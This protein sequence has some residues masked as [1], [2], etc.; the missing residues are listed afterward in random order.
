MERLKD[1]TNFNEEMFKVL[2]IMEQKGFLLESDHP[3]AYSMQYRTAVNDVCEWLSEN[4]Y[5]GTL[6]TDG[7]YD[8]YAGAVY[9]LYD[10]DRISYEEMQKE[11]AKEAKRQAECSGE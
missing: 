5:M 1:S 2:E 11:L 4:G 7:H 8:P 6:D 3:Y 10:K 9:G